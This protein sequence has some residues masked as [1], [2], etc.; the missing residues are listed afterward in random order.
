MRL[1]EC[2]GLLTSVVACAV[3]LDVGCGSRSARPDNSAMERVFDFGVARQ[4]ATIEHQFI[5]RNDTSRPLEISRIA[6]DCGCTVVSDLAGA[7]VAPASHLAIPV[8]LSLAGKRG[9]V[10][11]AITVYFDGETNDVQF[12]LHGRVVPEVPE[13]VTFE[14]LRRGE[15]QTREFE[16]HTFPGM[17]PVKVAGADYNRNNFEVELR[18][19]LNSD[20]TVLVRVLTKANLPEGAFSDTLVLHTNDSAAPDKQVPIEG[21]VLRRLEVS[22]K[23]IVLGDLS[24]GRA[25]KHELRIFSPYGEDVEVVKIDN[26]QPGLLAVETQERDSLDSVKVAVGLNDKDL[27][28]VKPGIVKG[29]LEFVC[30]VDGDEM[31]RRVEVYGYLR[32]Q[33]GK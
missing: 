11:Q 2:R 14:E 17:P 10:R 23:A 3:F 29:N 12:Q 32:P 31:W 4:G 28:A 5:F 13:K 19:S 6:T 8:K 16:L 22:E 1:Y 7:S 21:Y 15:Q 26:S 9:A 18:P 24:Q 33:S 20:S 30:R 27:N 25:E